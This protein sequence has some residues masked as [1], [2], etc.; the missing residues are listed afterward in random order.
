MLLSIKPPRKLVIAAFG[1]YIFTEVNGTFVTD[2]RQYVEFGNAIAK[3][4]GGKT[5]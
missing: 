3:A 2:D 1:A 4:V 5:Q